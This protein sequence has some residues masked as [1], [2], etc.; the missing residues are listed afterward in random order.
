[1]HRILTSIHNWIFKSQYPEV[2]NELMCRYNYVQRFIER[3]NT[4]I[5]TFIITND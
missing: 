3:K 1:M 4:V 5:F 2:L